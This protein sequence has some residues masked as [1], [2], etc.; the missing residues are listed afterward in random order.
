MSSDSVLTQTV[1]I[2]KT[3]L[4]SEKENYYV[5]CSF[6]VLTKRESL[7]IMIEEKVLVLKVNKNSLL[8]T[9]MKVNY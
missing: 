8:V 7:T 9:E 2:I 4:R 1:E 5:S 6:L 3:V